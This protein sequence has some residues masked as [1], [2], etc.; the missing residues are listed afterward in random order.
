MAQEGNLS[1][2]NNNQKSL[3]MFS[4]MTTYCLIVVLILI[5]IILLLIGIL[6]RDNTST[7]ILLTTLG[8]AFIV[9]I[10]TSLLQRHF[11]YTIQYKEMV[12]DMERKLH[13]LL[14]IQFDLLD[15]CSDIGIQHIYPKWSTFCENVLPER[16][17]TLKDSFV[18]VGTGLS[19]LSQLFQA[20]ELRERI[21]RKLSEGKSFTFCTALPDSPAIEYREREL[22]V[23]NSS[24]M[25]VKASLGYLEDILRANPGSDFSI[26]THEYIVP[27]ITIVCIDNEVIFVSPYYSKT[28]NP[29]TWVI[30]THKEDDLFQK[31]K[32]DLDHILK[33]AKDWP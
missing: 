20:G 27:K 16:L 2:N 12:S 30:E 28:R 18:A 10:S 13:A 5:G 32:D 26:K 24:N 9:S 6:L 11:T 7:S 17:E 23:K 1:M 8:V 29:S 31:L 14:R 3:F 15:S 33:D 25:A 4:R 19:G 22:G 21:D